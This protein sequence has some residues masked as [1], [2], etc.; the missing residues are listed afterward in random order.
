VVN[1]TLTVDEN[2]LKKARLRALQEDTSVNACVRAFLDQY[3]SGDDNSALTQQ[4]LSAERIIQM[5]QE[6][7]AGGGLDGRQW[8]R[9]DLYER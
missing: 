2:V 7:H 8:T 9:D 6:C 1:L 5:A 3:A 4:R